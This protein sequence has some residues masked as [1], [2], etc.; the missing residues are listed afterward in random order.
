MGGAHH[1]LLGVLG[2]MSAKNTV[3]NIMILS[4]FLAF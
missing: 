2:V 1:P 3:V 4:T